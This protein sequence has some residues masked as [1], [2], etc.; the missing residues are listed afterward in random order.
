L[1][2]DLTHPAIK[3]ND[4]ERQV[5]LAPFDVVDGSSFGCMNKARLLFTT[6]I[7]LVLTV[8]YGQSKTT[9]QF[10][11]ATVLIIRHAE[12]PETGKDLSPA[13]VRRAQAYT[14]YFKSLKIDSQPVKLDHLFA[15]QESK[16]S[17]RCRETLLSLSNALHLKI[18]S[19]FDTSEAQKLADKV[20]GSYSGEAVLICWHHGAIPGLLK[21]FG[22]NPKTLLP[23][24][25]WP[26]DVFGWLIV[27][28]Y[29][30]QG[31]LSAHVYNE[32]I[33]SED[34]RHPPPST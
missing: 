6:V 17:D 5:L 11:N 9:P 10:K 12:K 21:A 25:K 28:R 15:A 30:Q 26:E 1:A 24:G 13:G 23:G 18:H 16:H 7:F 32:A 4:V 2:G 8:E 27:L 33:T 22:A 19:K 34:V 20:S 29:D 14:G 31:N 3:S